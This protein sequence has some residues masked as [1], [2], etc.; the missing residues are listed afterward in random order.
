MTNKILTNGSIATK[1]WRRGIKIVLL[2]LGIIS[3]FLL[4][5]PAV[6][7]WLISLGHINFCGVLTKWIDNLNL[8]GNN[9]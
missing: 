1:Q 7:V 6:A 3:L 4:C 8:V 2:C 5:L 9:L